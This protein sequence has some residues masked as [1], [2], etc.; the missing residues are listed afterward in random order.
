M[1]EFTG[2]LHQ[3]KTHGMAQLAMAGTGLVEARGFL[4][5][6]A[7]CL[8]RLFGGCLGFAHVPGRGQQDRPGMVAQG[9]AVHG[10]GG[11]GDGFG[12]L[13]PLIDDAINL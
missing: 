8:G 7:A 10:L 12:E 13:L 3:V 4:R 9:G 11:R 6:F 5:A 1:T 2:H